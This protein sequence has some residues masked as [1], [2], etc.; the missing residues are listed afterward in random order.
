MKYLDMATGKWKLCK[1]SHSVKVFSKLQ[2]KQNQECSSDKEIRPTLLSQWLIISVE[3]KK[4]MTR[5][6]EVSQMQ[7]DH[8][9]IGL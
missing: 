1:L 6:L 2:N 5:F 3:Q 9:K 4:N 7:L 8:R